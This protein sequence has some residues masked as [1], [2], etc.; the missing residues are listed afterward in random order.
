MYYRYHGENSKGKIKNSQ[1]WRLMGAV[2]PPLG[3]RVWARWGAVRC[4]KTANCT[5]PSSLRLIPAPFDQ[6]YCL[7][8]INWELFS[9]CV[10][11]CVLLN[12]S[13]GLAEHNCLLCLVKWFDNSALIPA[14]IDGY[15]Y[16]CESPNPHPSLIPPHTLTHSQLVINVPICLAN[17]DAIRAS[18]MHWSSCFSLFTLLKNS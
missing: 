15:Q 18:L 10:W 9:V 7:K 5:L 8:A 2:L 4:T 17:K 1:I 13:V 14:G 11:V 3:R 12:T 16:L 6:Y